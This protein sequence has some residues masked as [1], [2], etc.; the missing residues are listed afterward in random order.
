MANKIKARQF[1]GNISKTELQEKEIKEF[2]FEI[3][4][5]HCQF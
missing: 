2:L 5:V 4:S 3:E 1:I